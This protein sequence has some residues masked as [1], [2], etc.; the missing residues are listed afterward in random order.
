LSKRKTRR[1]VACR[2]DLSAESYEKKGREEKNIAE[3]KRGGKKKDS[4]WL[5]TLSLSSHI[6]IP[7]LWRGKTGCQEKKGG[8]GGKL[9]L[10]PGPPSTAFQI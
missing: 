10:E 1:G 2:S 9:T 5:E 6:S 3:E 8:R 4:A 7:V